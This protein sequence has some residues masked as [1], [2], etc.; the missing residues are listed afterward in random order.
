MERM[1][2]RAVSFSAERAE[3]QMEVAGN[4]QPMG[5][6]HGGA[7]AVLVETA[8]SL[9]ATYA[10]PEGMV[11]VGSELSVS[12]LKPARTKTVS[13]VAEALRI[14]RS[15]AVYQV[16]VY[17]GKGSLTACGRMTGHFIPEPN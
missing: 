13:A 16:R 10:A 6:L 12:H 2:I 1:G 17:D 15:Q 11:A 4:T 7:N 5:I 3:I 14:G 8:A 9:A